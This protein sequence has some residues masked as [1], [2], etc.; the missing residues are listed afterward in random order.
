MIN[1]LQRQ[2]LGQVRFWSCSVGGYCVGITSNYLL[3]CLLFQMANL[4]PP[5]L[6]SPDP[7]LICI[8]LFE[9]LS[10]FLT[11]FQIRSAPDRLDLLPVYLWPGSSRGVHRPSGGNIPVAGSSQISSQTGFTRA[12]RFF[13]W[14]SGWSSPVQ[15][16]LGLAWSG[17][18]EL[19]RGFRIGLTINTNHCLH[20]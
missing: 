3:H 7:N 8:S 15:R 9:N 6:H 20:M 14:R 17:P 5:E 4:E 18:S 19:A 12:C 13:L 1:S 2:T 10:D 16:V 11:C